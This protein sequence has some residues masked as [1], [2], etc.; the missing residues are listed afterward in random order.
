LIYFDVKLCKLFNRMILKKERF[1][2]SM[3]CHKSTMIEDATT[4]LCESGCSYVWKKDR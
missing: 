1:C 2:P 3:P 4:W